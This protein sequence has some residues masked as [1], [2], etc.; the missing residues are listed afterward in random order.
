MTSSLTFKNT[1]RKS[2]TLALLATLTACNGSEQAPKESPTGPLAIKK[3]INVDNIDTAFS[4]YLLYQYRLET[5]IPALSSF[6]KPQ[7]SEQGKT[8]T[9]CP[10]QGTIDTIWAGSRFDYSYN[11][12][13]TEKGIIYSGG[14]SNSIAQGPTLSSSSSFDNLT[15]QSIDDRDIIKLSGF[16]RDKQSP[17]PRSPSFQLSYNNGT[18]TFQYAADISIQRTVDIKVTSISGNQHFVLTDMTNNY[19]PLTPLLSADDDSNITIA[20]NTDG[21][22]TLTLRNS[23]DS[24]LFTTKNYSKSEIENLLKG[25]RR[26]KI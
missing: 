21:S 15:Y 17:F 13:Q 3:S 10:K 16:A 26:V 19:E 24:Q 1:S 22:A 4:T 18:S 11:N 9:N 14:I 12:C 7:V 6:Y 20:R 25:A 8:T 5:E 2:I 23:K